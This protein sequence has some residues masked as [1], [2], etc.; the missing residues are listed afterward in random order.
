M[1]D[2]YAFR[3]SMAADR[4]KNKRIEPGCARWP[5]ET[6]QVLVATPDGHPP[7]GEAY[8]AGQGPWERVWSLKYVENLYDMGFW[9]NLGDIFVRDYTFGGKDG[10]ELAVET[11]QNRR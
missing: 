2:G 6:E 5:V 10:G 3:R 9:D 7:N 4:K 1:N 11:K 8:A